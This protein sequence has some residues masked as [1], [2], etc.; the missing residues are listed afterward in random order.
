MLGGDVMVT[1]EWHLV[2]QELQTLA[3]TRRLPVF[4]CQN[5]NIPSSLL[6]PMTILDFQVWVKKPSPE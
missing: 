1:A 4:R 5:T 6:A 2:W 3:F